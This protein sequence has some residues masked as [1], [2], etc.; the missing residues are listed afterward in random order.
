M[1]SLLR[2]AAR[3]V[4]ELAELAA[5]IIHEDALLIDADIEIQ[6]CRDQ[7]ALPP[8]HYPF[9]SEHENKDYDECRR[10][11]LQEQLSQA[12]DRIAKTEAKTARGAAIKLKFAVI[13]DQKAALRARAEAIA[14]EFDPATL[15]EGDAGLIEAERR[16]QEIEARETLLCDELERVENCLPFDVE[17]LG[18]QPGR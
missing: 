11:E 16:I 1:A 9:R 3:Q 18:Q 5:P 4:P 15:P 8:H 14:A 10:T 2:D 12:R 17:I 7:L 6:W 13:D